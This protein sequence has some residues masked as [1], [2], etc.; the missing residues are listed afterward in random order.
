MSSLIL[1]LKAKMLQSTELLQQIASN[2][3]RRAGRSPDTEHDYMRM[4]SHGVVYE[5]FARVGV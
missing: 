3:S 5:D 4:V 2:R 1:S